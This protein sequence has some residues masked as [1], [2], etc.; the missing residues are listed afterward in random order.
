M[1]YNVRIEQR[2]NGGNDEIR[3]RDLRSDSAAL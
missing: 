3:T 1:A 2:Y